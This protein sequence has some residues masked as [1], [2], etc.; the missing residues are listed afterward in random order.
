MKTKKYSKLISLI[1]TIGLILSC[2]SSLGLVCSAADFSASEIENEI[3]TKY[4]V[5][6]GAD[7]YDE[8][9]I[10]QVFR[11]R[12][13]TVH[14]GTYYLNNDNSGKYL[15]YSSS[16]S[17]R[18]G[19]ISSLGN[20]IRW[21]ITYNGSY[22]YIQPVSDSTKYFAVSTSSGSNAVELVTVTSSTVPT[23]CKWSI[24]IATGGG[25][26]VKNAYNSKY[27]KLSG[28]SVSA[29]STT[30]TSGTATYASCVWR[31]A[32][33]DYYGN[34]SSHT[35]RELMSGF[36]ITC[37]NVDVGETL[38]Q[39]V[40]KNPTNALWANKYDFTYT[41]SNTSRVSI[42]GYTL[43]A[44]SRGSASITATH[45]VTG[46]TKTFSVSI[47]PG[48]FDVYIFASGISLD[49]MMS[50]SMA[51]HGWIEII[52]NSAH[53]YTI[54]HYEL[55]AG[56]AVT[57]GRWGSQIDQSTDGSF[58]GLWYNREIYEMNI[59]D[60][61]GSKTYSYVTASKAQIDQITSLILSS[62]NGYH[63]TSNNC[64]KFAISAW[65]LCADSNNRISTSIIMPDGLV[66]AIEDLDVHFSGTSTSIPATI[67]CGFYN[68]ST[69]IEH[70]LPN[71][72][73]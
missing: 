16:L 72:L 69:Y 17:A 65:N 6:A 38:N 4:D 30:G 21:E 40:T 25:C 55:A 5:L 20:S 53:E 39:K 47:F 64:V 15:R 44:L 14:D 22:Y 48:T 43:T 49:N 58:V 7:T 70:S 60:K 56:E 37:N 29:T 10:E 45:K 31:V 11:T 73:N 42:N 32:G 18:S 54:G 63:L 59:N 51:G 8:K 3:P 36:S 28:S 62:Y 34:T 57:I 61:Y 52:S 19:L 9:T 46:L 50:G 23:Q 66:N 13:Q 33:T 27:L 1:L 12:S 24:S 68:G 67:T 26:L 2:V 71:S 35:K 41:T